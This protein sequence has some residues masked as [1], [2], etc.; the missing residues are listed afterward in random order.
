M[1]NLSSKPKT[2]TDA[3]IRIGS[4]ISAVRAKGGVNTT[5]FTQT[6]SAPA[7]QTNQSFL[8]NIC[9]LTAYLGGYLG[10]PEHIM[11]ANVYLQT[12]FAAGI[13]SFVLPITT[14]LNPSKVPPVWPY[15]GTPMLVA[16]DTSDTIISVNGISLEQFITAILEYKSVS[17]YTGEPILL[18]LEDALSDIDRSKMNYVKFMKTIAGQ[19]QALDPYRVT[20]AGSYGSIVGGKN[21]KK[22]LTEIP[23][24][25]FTN[26]IVIFTNFDTA[27]DDTQSLASYA[28]FIYS[29]TNNTLPVRE[30][31]LEDVKGSTVNLVASA[32]TNWLIAKSKAPLTL[33]TTATIQGALASGI[34]CIPIPLLA[35]PMAD[36]ADVWRLWN[37]AS[38]SLKQ[39]NA[40]YTSPSPVVPA[41]PSLRLNASIQ[42]KEPGT[43][44][45]G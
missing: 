31:A 15:S 23:L 32:R 35:V 45:V 7:L 18:F 33:P 14:Y 27:Q 16:R 41:A 25:F 28:N 30:M 21:Q 29:P 11:D 13:R 38:Y 1:G 26:K 9:P 8:V 3:Q 44:V 5:F 42:G 34:Q 19:L 24:S 39:E 37:G 2:V 17:G 4:E 22:L 12:A 36:V 43:L 40:R 10:P 6:N 20:T